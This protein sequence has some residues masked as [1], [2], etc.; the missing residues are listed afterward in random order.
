[1]SAPYIG[2][3]SIFAGNYPPVN[4]A[5]CNGQAMSVSEYQMLF[6][7]IGTTYGGN[8]VTT[9]MLPDLRGRV[10]VG[11]GTATGGTINWVAGMSRGNETVTLTEA[12]IPPHNHPLQA[13]SQPATLSTP[14]GNTLAADAGGAGDFSFTDDTSAI[15]PFLSTA[16]SAE[17]GSL[18]HNNVAPFM[19]LNYIIALQGI[20]PSRN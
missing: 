4:W 18:P 16:V 19:A 12:Q 10:P 13:T 7:L 2:Q 9:F 3:I 20:F 14:G 17:G 6:A 11:I 8:G 5:F 15:T 1:M